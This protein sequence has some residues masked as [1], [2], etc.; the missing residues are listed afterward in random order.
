MGEAR[1]RV[2]QGGSGDEGDTVEALVRNE[3]SMV[4][5]G[6]VK[7]HWWG[8]Y[9]R[10]MVRDWVE[11]MRG[12]GDAGWKI[13]WRW[14]G[15]RPGETVKCQWQKIVQDKDWE[16]KAVSCGLWVEEARQGIKQRRWQGIKCW[17]EWGRKWNMSYRDTEKV[18]L[19]GGEGGV[20]S[21]GE[22]EIG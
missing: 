5:E 13:K 3:R 21:F 17:N 15:K 12:E 6:W 18:Y 22:G 20:W 10:E 1:W 4:G 19:K 7:G 11:K 16:Q 9:K 8:L 14:Q 2:K